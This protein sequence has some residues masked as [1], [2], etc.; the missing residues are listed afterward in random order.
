MNVALL[1]LGLRLAWP[2]LSQSTW[3]HP[4]LIVTEF[5][6]SEEVLD[7]AIIWQDEISTL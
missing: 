2:P 7:A 5:Y 4:D 3:I 6:R 1:G